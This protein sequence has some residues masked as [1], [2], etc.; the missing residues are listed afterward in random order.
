MD[1]ETVERQRKGNSIFAFLQKAVMMEGLVESP[2]QRV[3]ERSLAYL[4]QEQ[5]VNRNFWGYIQAKA[6]W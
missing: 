5:V 2:T 1:E 6:G 4:I 3:I